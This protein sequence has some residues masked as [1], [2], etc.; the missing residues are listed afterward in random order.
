M[1]INQ[2]TAFPCDE[3]TV[4]GEQR[5]ERPGEPRQDECIRLLNLIDLSTFQ[6]V[7]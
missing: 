2:L 3:A 4:G 6:A 7:N 5:Y 1:I